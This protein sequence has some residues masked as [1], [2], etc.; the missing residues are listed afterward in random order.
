MK[1][2]FQ[3]RFADDL[4]AIQ[5]E[6]AILEGNIR[7]Y[8]AF[9]SAKTLMIYCNGTWCSQA[10]ESIKSV[11]GFSYPSEKIKYFRNG[12]QGWEALGLTTVGC[13]KG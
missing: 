13:G 8:C 12:M 6:K 9:S 10:S 2:T 1:H 7:Q 4:D 11:L 5:A 3:V